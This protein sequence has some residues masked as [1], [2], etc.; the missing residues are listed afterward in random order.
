MPTVP[1]R[2]E[3]R[4][5]PLRVHESLDS[6]SNLQSE[7]LAKRGAAR[8]CRAPLGNRRGARIGIDERALTVIVALKLVLLGGFGVRQRGG[9]A[10]EGDVSFLDR[11]GSDGVTCFFGDHQTKVPRLDEDSCLRVR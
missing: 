6:L 8:E 2:E 10:L 9:Q 5:G 7:G 4:R 1:E 11:G 3:P